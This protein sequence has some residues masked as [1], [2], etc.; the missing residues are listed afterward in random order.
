[1]IVALISPYWEGR[2][3]ARGISGHIPFLE[4]YIDTPQVLCELHDPKGLYKH[5]RNDDIRNFTSI[6]DPYEMPEAPDL[7]LRTHGRTVEQSSTPLVM[8]VIELTTLGTS[9]IGTLNF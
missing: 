8:K 3:T 9:R 7:V 5:A 1:M 4:V 6:S 2:S